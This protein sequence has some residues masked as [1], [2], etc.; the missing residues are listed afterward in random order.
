MSSLR[1]SAV[2]LGLLAL[3]TMP[4]AAENQAA[5]VKIGMLAN[6]FRDIKP[7]LLGTL[8][9]PFHSIVRSQTGMTSDL[10]LVPTGDELSKQLESKKIHFGVYH[11]FEYAWL[12]DKYPDIVPLMIAA[13]QRRPMRVYVVVHAS[14]PATTLAELKGKNFAIPLGTKEHGRLFL[15]RSCQAV[16]GTTDQFFSK[17]V[18]P[19]SQEDAMHEVADGKDVHAAIVELSGLDSFA[20][21]FPIRNRK[22]KILATSEPFP[23]SVVCYYKG[24]VDDDMIRRFRDGMSTAHNSVIGKQLLGFWNMSGFEPIPADYAASLAT[25]SKI[26][27]PPT[28]DSKSSK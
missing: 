23:P 27:P 19:A 3:S 13:P 6:M 28:D 24:R 22:V 8:T 15:E 5:T 7:S 9:K 16:G 20:S 17:V 18:T 1:L 25:I 2:L 4:A 10:V 26:Y 11:G 12:C 21:R 14:N